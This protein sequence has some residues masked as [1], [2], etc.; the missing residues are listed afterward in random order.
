[1]TPSPSTVGESRSRRK[2]YD[3]QCRLGVLLTWE[4][5][6]G[7]TEEEGRTSH[8]S[9]CHEGRGHHHPS[10][11]RLGLPDYEPRSFL[12]WDYETFSNPRPSLNPSC[13]SK[14][15]TVRT[16]GL[17]PA[18]PD[19]RLSVSRC[20]CFT[21]TCHDP[22]QDLQNKRHCETH[23]KG[24]CVDCSCDFVSHEFSDRVQMCR[25]VTLSTLTVGAVCGV[26]KRV[27][28]VGTGHAAVP[29][30]RLRVGSR[31]KGDT[32]ETV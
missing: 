18:R 15:S 8:T 13:M 7:L 23:H 19:P 2:G 4:T 20:K 31:R 26:H 28:D 21:N 11:T 22:G 16:W 10:L 29:T 27:D 14:M 32:V 9:P 1:M 3:G 5:F 12:L 30:L 6:E 17:L 24:A 25:S